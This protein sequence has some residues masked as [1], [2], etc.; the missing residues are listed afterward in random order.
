[1]SSFASRKEELGAWR[2]T[3]T[4][5]SPLSIAR[6]DGDRRPGGWLLAP[7]GVGSLE[8]VQASRDVSAGQAEGGDSPVTLD[9]ISTS[10][11]PH[12]SVTPMRVTAVRRHGTV[13]TASWLPPKLAE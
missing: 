13:L 6:D 8:P 10:R 1:M 7:N 3:L 12:L 5:P 4:P 9:G 2:Q 11:P